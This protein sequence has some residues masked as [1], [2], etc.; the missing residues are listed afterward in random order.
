MH[1]RSRDHSF[2]E[3]SISIVDRLGIYLSKRLILSHFPIYPNI[4]ALDIGCGY[5][6]L[7]LKMISS[8]ISSGVG[9][10]LKIDSE[11]KNH[12]KLSF[13]ES[14]IETGFSSLSHHS[15][16]LVLLINVL[17]HIW[18]PLFILSECFRVMR[19]NAVLM[20]NVPTWIGKWFLEL[21]AFRLHTSPACEMDD[22]KMYYN[23]K[24]LWPS[25]VRAGFKPSCIR[26][27]YH[28]F[29]LCLFSVCHK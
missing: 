13:I 14:P 1:D 7:H 11:I 23:K 21:S 20:I 16:D 10:D 4:S 22:H 24:D 29:G 18:D 9:I 8:F 27:N 15:F 3:Q 6:A 12:P 19:D 25:L 26:M 28:K 2:G 17:E 5:C